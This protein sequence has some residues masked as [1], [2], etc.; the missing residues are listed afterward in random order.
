MLPGFGNMLMARELIHLSGSWETGLE[1]WTFNGFVRNFSTDARTGDYR[2]RATAGESAEYTIAD[3]AGRNLDFSVWGKNISVTN[4]DVWY[5][6]GAGAWISLG[7]VALP[8][9]EV[10]ARVLKSFPTAAGQTASVKIE[11]D[12][13]AD[14]DDW[15]IAE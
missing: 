2:V 10:Y 15:S 5:R 14:F 1:G 13:D 9:G 7:T 11:V 3:P 6:I 4:V 8:P 12:G